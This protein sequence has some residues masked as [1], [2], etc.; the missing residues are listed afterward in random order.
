MKFNFTYK[1]GASCI[2]NIDCDDSISVENRIKIVHEIYNFGEKYGDIIYNSN[3]SEDCRLRIFDNIDK[4]ASWDS[5][6]S[7]FKK[8]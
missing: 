6:I 8:K 7:K 5:F 3:L 2:V 1:N 4:P